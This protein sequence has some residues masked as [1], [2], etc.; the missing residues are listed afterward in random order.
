MRYFEIERSIQRSTITAW[1]YLL[2]FLL[3]FM[4]IWFTIPLYFPEIISNPEIF[5]YNNLTTQMHTNR[6]KNGQPKPASN[7]SGV[8]AGQAKK[9]ISI[10]KSEG[11]RDIVISSYRGAVDN[12]EFSLF[13]E[14][15]FF[16]DRNT[17]NGSGNNLV[18]GG[19]IESSTYELL[20][21][22]PINFAYKINPDYP[23]VAL[24]A[25][26]TG[27]VQILLYIDIEGRS[28]KFSEN[29]NGYFF[30]ENGTNKIPYII[31]KEEP[32]DWFFARNTEKV[33]SFWRF[34]P[35][36]ENGRPVGAFLR[37]TYQFCLESNCQDFILNP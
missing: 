5:S 13:C 27:S 21:N 20:L 7:R 19:Y 2:S 12:E 15:T 36:I 9:K 28:V 6:G 4:S 18:A 14:S 33:I 17:L 35:R 1:M 25:G 3:I 30:D 26:K 29:K 31:L 37:L 16:C 34:T 32:K 10:V 11:R 22:R 24:E 23:L 8:F